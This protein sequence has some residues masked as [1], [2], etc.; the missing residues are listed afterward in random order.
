MLLRRLLP[1]LVLPAVVGLGIWWIYSPSPITVET[2]AVTRGRFVALVEAEGRTRIKDRYVI[3]APLA[4]SLM[5]PDVRPGDAVAAGA[6]LATILPAPAPLLDARLRNEAIERVGAAEAM[7]RAADAQVIR[8]ERRKAQAQI[9][10]DRKEGLSQRGIVT[11]LA[12]EQAAL[13]ADLAERDV[14]ASRLRLQA[15]QH[16]LAMAQTL[17]RRTDESASTERLSITAPI[18]GR[19]LRVFQENATTVAAGSPLVEMGDETALEVIVDVLTADAVAMQAGS[20][21]YLSRWGGPTDLLGRVRLVEPSGFTKLSALGVEEQRVNVVIDIV[22]PREA[23]RGLADGFRVDVAIETRVRADETLVP[24]TALFRR[25]AGWAVF[26]VVDGKARLKS[27][28]IADRSGAQAVVTQG[29]APGDT[30][31]VFPP[32]SLADG[33]AVTC[34]TQDPARRL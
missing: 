28:T 22:S 1:A 20:V 5:R 30:V 3:S 23:W 18:S 32:S 21:A 31:I 13:E 7:M 6:V 11:E 25:G 4:G 24:S 2:Q 29:V 14:I 12:R 26:V 27:V 15:A 33:L 10:L 9:E 16:N 17:L 19:V 8:D 34:A